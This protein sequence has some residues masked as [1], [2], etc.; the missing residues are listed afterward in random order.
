MMAV[1]PVPLPPTIGHHISHKPIGRR[2]TKQLGY[3]GCLPCSL[4]SYDWSQYQSLTN[5]KEAYKTT[6]I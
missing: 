3:D 2:L 1:F 5:R 6:G 4:A